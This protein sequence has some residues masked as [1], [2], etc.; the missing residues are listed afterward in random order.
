MKK[1]T[2]S[3]SLLGFSLLM[4]YTTL[5]VT[6]KKDLSPVEQ[7]FNGDTLKIFLGNI[8]NLI[9]GVTFT[10]ATIILIYGALISGVQY[11]VSIL[12]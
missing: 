7:G 4:P 5:A 2:L 1:R 10:L 8:K 6:V 3:L 11:L 12:A 9:L